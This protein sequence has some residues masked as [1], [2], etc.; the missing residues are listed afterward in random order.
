M[1]SLTITIDD[2]VHKVISKRAKKNMMT[3]REQ[4]E[5]IVR[6]SAVNAGSGSSGDGKLDDTL[7]GVF[8]R[9]GRKKN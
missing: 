3:V 9:K 1:P 8:S 5:D 6:R 2:K 4:V 7:V